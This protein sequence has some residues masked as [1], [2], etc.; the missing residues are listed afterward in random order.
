MCQKFKIVFF[1]W[2]KH[3]SPH[4]MVFQEG[5]KKTVLRAIH[6]NNVLHKLC[7]SLSGE[8]EKA[9]ESGWTRGKGFWAKQREQRGTQRALFPS[10][11]QSPSVAVP[12]LQTASARFSEWPTL[13]LDNFLSYWCYWTVTPSPA[14]TSMYASLSLRKEQ[15]W[16]MWPSL[17]SFGQRVLWY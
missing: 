10:R 17:R 13:W 1:R 4:K 16:D 3:H 5:V 12:H 9:A 11:L 15:Q 8:A 14:I 6:A 2:N 7:S